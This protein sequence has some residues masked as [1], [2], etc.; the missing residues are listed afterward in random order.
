MAAGVAALALLFGAGTALAALHGLPGRASPEALAAE[1]ALRQ[2]WAGGPRCLLGPNR[3]EPVPGCRFGD[4]APGAPA[5]A[6]FGD[7][8][9]NHHM[10]TLDAVTREAGLGLVQLTKA[11]CA[12]GVPEPPRLL[13]TAE[14]RACNRFR[15][16]AVE[17]ILADPSIRAVVMAGNWVQMADPA[18]AMPGVKAAAERFLASGRAVVLVT[19]PV[20]FGNG[21]GRCVM[22]RRFLGLSDDGCA[23]PAAPSPA[24]ATVEGARRHG[25][26]RAAG[27]AGHRPPHPVRAGPVPRHPRRRHRAGGQRPS[28]LCRI[29]GAGGRLPGRLRIPRPCVCGGQMSGAG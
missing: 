16:A 3:F 15:A 4:P 8:F 17:A 22:R 29:A 9:A 27:A 23:V 24:A 12:P 28:Q 18:A 20:I 11:G 10:V 19:P 6:L 26:G 14:A 5:V 2:R 25:A 21:G 1:A 7:S 13:Q